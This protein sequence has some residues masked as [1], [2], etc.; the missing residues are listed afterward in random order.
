MDLF[1][2][3]LVISLA[4]CGFM[5]GLVWFVHHVH[6]PGFRFVEPDVWKTFH[7]FHT[8]RTGSV[9]AVPMLAE[10][11]SAIL[12]AVS[13]TSGTLTAWMVYAA[14]FLLILVWYETGLKVIP[15]HNKMQ[16]AAEH[17]IKNLAAELT[18]SNRKR[19][20]YWLIRFF[21]LIF[22]VTFSV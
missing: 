6:Y 5:T 3:S 14:L 9:V 11:L 19:S 20:I 1:H 17:G 18:R 2:L 8:S 7:D 13:V 15:V 4:S 21:L 16:S 22:I 10:L 12:L